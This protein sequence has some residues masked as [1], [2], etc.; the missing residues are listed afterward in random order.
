MKIELLA[1]IF[2]IIP[3][4][5]GLTMF[6]KWDVKRIDQAKRICKQ[7]CNETNFDCRNKCFNYAYRGNL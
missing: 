3:L 6:I 2:I 4:I 7:I 5:I 1:T